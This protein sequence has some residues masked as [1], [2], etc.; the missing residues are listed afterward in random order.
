MLFFIFSE[1][2]RRREHS[3]PT[4]H[5]ASSSMASRIALDPDAP[6]NLHE[7]FM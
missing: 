3:T 5:D 6:R 7:T 2:L 4:I 1:K